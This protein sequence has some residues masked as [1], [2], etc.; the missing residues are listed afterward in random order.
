MVDSS[1]PPIIDA[2]HLL[3]KQRR[4]REAIFTG[5]MWTAYAYLWTPLLSLLA[6]WTG[7]DI[8]YEAMVEQGGW[9]GLLSVMRWY[10]IG[11]TLIFVVVATWSASNRRRFRN[12]ERR[13]FTPPVSDHE[14]MLKFAVGSAQLDGMRQWSVM[15]VD[16]DQSGNILDVN[17]SSG[18]EAKKSE[19]SAPEPETLSAN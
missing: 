15:T 11:I 10:L 6:W 2:P 12:Q 18:K 16:L 19:K 17:A 5:I 7:L 3:S 1:L 13:Q 8:A 9:Q 14:L 4:R